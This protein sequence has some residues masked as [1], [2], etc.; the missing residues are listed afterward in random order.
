MKEQE[1]LMLKKNYEKMSNGDLLDRL[2]E[3][4]GEYTEIAYELLL[5]EGKRRGID[6]Q[7]NKPKELR[8]EETSDDD[9]IE[10]SALETVDSE[11]KFYCGSVSALLIIQVIV[12]AIRLKITNFAEVYSVIAMLLNLSII[13]TWYCFLR[14]VHRMAKQFKIHNV[15]KTQPWIWVVGSLIPIFSLMVILRMFNYGRKLLKKLRI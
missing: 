10:T 9:A 6:E 11:Y 3:G 12:A 13:I 2:A 1:R 8:D 4:R 14:G 15:T 7:I 5:E